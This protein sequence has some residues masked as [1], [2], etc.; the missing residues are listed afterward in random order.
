MEPQEHD[1]LWTLLG[2][3][4]PKKASG[5]FVQNTLREVRKSQSTANEAGGSWLDFFKSPV[6]VGS[7]AA[8]IVLTIAILAIPQTPE[9]TGIASIPTEE[10]TR[11]VVSGDEV[12]ILTEELEVLTM[13]SE[14]LAVSDPSYL[15]DAALA[16]L[17][18]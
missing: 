5:A 11:S 16:E 13:V 8:L 1:E 9:K 12:D 17:L 7:F 15:D 3:S 18:F 4:P 14:F 2:K 10:S 6:L